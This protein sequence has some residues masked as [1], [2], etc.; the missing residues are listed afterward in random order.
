MDLKL[1]SKVSPGNINVRV[2]RWLL[3]PCLWRRLLE[4]EVWIERK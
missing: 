1:G 2:R 3:N 4:K